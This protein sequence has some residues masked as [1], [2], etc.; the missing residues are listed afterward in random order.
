VLRKKDGPVAPVLARLARDGI[1]GGVDLGRWNT[2]WSKDL[3]LAVTERHSKADLDR[4][5]AALA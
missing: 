5:V 2:A 1:L 4:L 3:L